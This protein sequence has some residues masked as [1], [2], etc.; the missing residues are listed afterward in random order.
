VADEGNVISNTGGMRIT[1]KTELLREKELSQR[2][3][4]FEFVSHLFVALP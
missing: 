3:P 1:R 2:R 4:E